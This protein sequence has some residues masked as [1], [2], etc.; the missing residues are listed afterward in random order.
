V[1]SNPRR[2]RRI[3][4]ASDNHFRTERGCRHG[5]VRWCSRPAG[6]R[7]A[8]SSPALSFHWRLADRRRGALRRRGGRE[9]PCALR[10]VDQEVVAEV[11]LIDL[12]LDRHR[13]D[14]VRHDALEHDAGIGQR[15]CNASPRNGVGTEWPGFFAMFCAMDSRRLGNRPEP[16]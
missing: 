3:V 14:L 7:A 12:A 9:G 8:A 11:V 5:E 2:Y 4:A 15:T 13:P 16:N 6:K 1:P 10:V